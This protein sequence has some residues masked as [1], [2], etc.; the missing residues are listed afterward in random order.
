M[1]GLWHPSPACQLPPPRLLRAAAEASQQLFD[2]TSL[3]TSLPSR[4]MNPAGQT[5]VIVMYLLSQNN[6]NTKDLLLYLEVDVCTP[7]EEIFESRDVSIVGTAQQ[8]EALELH[9]PLGVACV[10]L[11]SLCLVALTFRISLGF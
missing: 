1:P 9:G 3:H 4:R 2:L 6:N 11:G 7:C 10:V 5:E 8:P